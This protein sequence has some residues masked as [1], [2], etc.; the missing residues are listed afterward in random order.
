[1][2]IAETP[3]V[4]CSGCYGQYPDRVH[5]DFE[6]AWDG[7]VFREAVA[8]GD[9][10]VQQTLTVSIDELVLCDRCIRA[11][12]ALVNGVKPDPSA[13]RI[14]ELERQL[15]REREAAAGKDDYIRKLENAVAAKAPRQPVGA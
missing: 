1:M 14:A 13:Q 9:G 15:R 11:A 4:R 7:P 12:A 2:R 5:V 10:G 3:P 8:T 6:T